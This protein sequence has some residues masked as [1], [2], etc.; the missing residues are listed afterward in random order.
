M[1]W[2]TMESQQHIINPHLVSECDK[3]SAIKLLNSVRF[4]ITRL[5]VRQELFSDISETAGL[6]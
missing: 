6:M 4:T 3:Y 2:R 5:A 1:F